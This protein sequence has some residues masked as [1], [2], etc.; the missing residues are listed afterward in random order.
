MAQAAN[1]VLVVH[2]FPPINSSG[3]KRMEAMSKYFARWGRNVTVIATRKGAIDGAFTEVFP[4]GVRVLELDQAGRLS[5]STSAPIAADIEGFGPPQTGWFRSFK[6]M[7]MRAMGQLPDPRLP[8]ALSFGGPT[9]APEARQALATA[10]VVVGT[11]PPWPP[12]LAVL[13]AKRRF[14][15]PAVLDYRDQLSM[16]HEMPGS[17]AAKALEIRLDRWLTRRADLV[18]T[19]SEPMRGY[20]RKYHDNVV[21]ILNG[22]DHEKIEDA[23]T[24][25][26]W[27]P[28]PGQPL[29]IRY[30]GII[31]PGR[32][33][34]EMLAALLRLQAKG[35]SMTE[36]FRFE[37]VGECD[38]L[39]TVIQQEYASLADLFH[40]LPRVSYEESLNRIVSADFLMFCENG[41]PSNS[42]QEA[43]A[44]GILTTKLFEYLA[45]G[46]PVIA[47]IDEDTLA[48]SFI[49]KA[50]DRHFVSN[51]VDAF[52]QFLE[53]LSLALAGDVETSDFV[54]SLSRERQAMQ[55]L[56]SLDKIVRKNRNHPF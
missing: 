1:I 35:V 46:R 44:S 22:Y 43:S 29:I 53:S 47:N 32:I 27:Q 3:A 30:L 45:S 55:Y 5:P 42:G 8:F 19:I 20:Y 33:P 13:L 25:V 2:Y 54:K 24:R 10:D 52:E 34:R 56:D 17:R 16:C 9:L 48:G 14:G 37:Y 38:V 51:K 41:I 4:D 39:K 28:R 6:N 26:P 49:K 12:L 23:R 36:R 7:V 40:F 15:V 50:S 31:T 11:C 21:A 18:V